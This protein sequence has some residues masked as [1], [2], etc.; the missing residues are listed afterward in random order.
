MRV[1]ECLRKGAADLDTAFMH[2]R[3]LESYQTSRDKTNKDNPARGA[4]RDNYQARTVTKNKA[5]QNDDDGVLAKLVQSDENTQHEIRNLKSLSEST[6]KAVQELSQGLNNM[7]VRVIPPAAMAVSQIAPTVAAGPTIPTSPFHPGTSLQG[8]PQVNTYGYPFANSVNGSTPQASSAGHVN[9][10]PGSSVGQNQAPMNPTGVNG[11][12]SRK[13][14]QC[15]NCNGYGH[16][17]RDCPA[18]PRPSTGN[19]YN[20]GGSRPL[21]NMML[22]DAGSRSYLEVEIAGN[23]HLCLLDSGSDVTL[24]P[25]S[26]ARGR[27]LTHTTQKLFAA[28]GA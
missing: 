18:P 13:P 20:S 23:K 15:Y 1:R 7:Q 2:A 3:R 12:G 28:G 11:A 24:I 17:K 14:P 16:I 27:K 22:K 6:F 19:P 21:Q 8:P 4:I 25:A 10:F 26:I 5:N 9:N